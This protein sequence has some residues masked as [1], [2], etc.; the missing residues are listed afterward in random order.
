MKVEVLDELELNDLDEDSHHSWTEPVLN[1]K[2]YS[3]KICL[4]ISCS[5]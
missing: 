5:G 4:T 2:L 3:F 1:G